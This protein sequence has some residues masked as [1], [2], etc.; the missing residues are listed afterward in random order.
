MVQKSAKPVNFKDPYCDC[1]P[2]TTEIECAEY[3][4]ETLRYSFGAF[5]SQFLHFLVPISMFQG[6]T[7]NRNIE[8]YHLTLEHGYRDNHMQE[9]GV[10]YAKYIEEILLYVFGVFYS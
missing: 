6:Q 7:R 2:P 3:I 8:Y 1:F 9:L 5:D 10:E 4:E